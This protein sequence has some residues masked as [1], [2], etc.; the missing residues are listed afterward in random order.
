MAKP[1]TKPLPFPMFDADRLTVAQQRNLDAFAS[2][3]QIVVDGVKAMA[4]RQSEMMRASVDQFVAANQGDKPMEFQPG[5]QIAKAKSMYEVA[6]NNTKELAEIAMK[7]QS[8][9]VDVLTKCA[10]ANI[11]DLKSLA[12]T[13]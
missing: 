9:A 5:D 6:V 4:Q 8:E 7:A 12:K 2:A 13:A 3:S 1:T 11:D 10:M